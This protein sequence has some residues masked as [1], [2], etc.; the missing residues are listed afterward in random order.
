MHKS[1][2]S[3]KYAYVLNHAYGA[4]AWWKIWCWMSSIKTQF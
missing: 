3:K 1:V 2:F 4:V